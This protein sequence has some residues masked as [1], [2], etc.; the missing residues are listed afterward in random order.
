MNLPEGAMIICWD[1]LPHLSHAV[2]DK[3]H[4]FVVK[5]LRRA[6]VYELLSGGDVNVRLMSRTDYLWHERLRTAVDIA[7]GLAHLHKHRPEVFHRDIKTANILFGLDGTAKIADFGLACV[8]KLRGVREL[9]VD[10]TAGTPG[11]V[12]PLYSQTGV[13]TEAN[14]VYSFGMVLLELITGRPPAVVA[15]DGRGIIFLHEEFKPHEEGAKQRVLTQLDI[16]AQWPS[17]TVSSLV[18]V[19]LLCVHRDTD[20]R[21]SFVDV[22]TTLQFLASTSNEP[23]ETDEN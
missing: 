1:G 5:T 20:R 15:E 17:S 2:V 11:Y 6:L 7:R 12:D 13:V 23:V 9:A 3:N 14:E 22:A 10:S 16:R 21:P 4:V 8:S 18:T 19:A